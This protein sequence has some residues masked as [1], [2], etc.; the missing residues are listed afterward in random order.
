L[1]GAD[2]IQE[3]RWI[4]HWLRSNRRLDSGAI[5][6]KLGSHERGSWSGCCEKFWIQLCRMRKNIRQCLQRGPRLRGF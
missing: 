2:V 5:R 6:R 1:T 3:M 4:S